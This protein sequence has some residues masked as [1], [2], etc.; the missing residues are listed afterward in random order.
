MDKQVK[1]EK[2]LGAMPRNTEEDWEKIRE[3][4][5]QLK[6]MPMS[7]EADQ[8]LREL[9]PPSSE[10]PKIDLETRIFYTRDTL[11]TQNYADY[12]KEENDP[13]LKEKYEKA[14]KVIEQKKNLLNQV[15]K[16]FKE[17]KATIEE[18]NKRIDELSIIDPLNP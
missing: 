12:V 13:V 8:L 4:E 16:D 9:A 7:S 10:Q 17:G 14:A 11:V 5:R 18:C 1:M 3:A 2:E 6:E 15:E